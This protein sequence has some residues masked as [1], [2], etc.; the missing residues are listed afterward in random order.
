MKFAAFA[1]AAFALT[2]LPAHAGFNDEDGA[3]AEVE[4][5]IH[6]YK[7]RAYQQGNV[8][9]EVFSV[10]KSGPLEDNPC[11]AG[12]VIVDEIDAQT[13]EIVNY[14]DTAVVICD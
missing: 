13:V 12:S 3:S 8:T 7:A 6:Q 14:V 9:D 11:V 4:V 2:A 1:V 5:M 10:H